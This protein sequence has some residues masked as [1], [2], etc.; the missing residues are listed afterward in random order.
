M[1]R[2]QPVIWTKGTILTPQHL[3]AQDRFIESTLQ[4]HLDALSFQPWG[5]REL[6]IDQAALASGLFSVSSAS[7]IFP[8]GLIFDV[9]DSDPP[10]APKPLPDNFGSG[11]DTL[12]LYL[13]IPSFQER[14]LNVSSAARGARTRYTAETAP[15]IDEN[16]GAS[17]RSIQIARKNLSILLESENL[18][19]SAS[20]RIARVRKSPAGLLQLDS[21]FIPPLLDISASDGLMAMVRGLSDRLSARSGGISETRRQKNPSL[22]DFTASDIANFWLLYTLNSHL[23]A[24]RHLAETRRAHPEALFAALLELAGALTAF[25]GKIR[26]RDLPAY[27]HAD[28]SSCFAE[29]EGKLKLL[30]ETVV[31]DNF[32]SFA[33]KRVR[34]SVYSTALTDEKYLS[35]TMYLAVSAGLDAAELGARVP[36]YIKVGSLDRVD[37]MVAKALSGVSLTHTASPPEAIRV[38][39]NYQYFRLDQS[40]KEWD[41]ICRAHNLAAF[42]PGDFGSPQLELIVIAPGR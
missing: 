21:R 38:K 8:D 22:A 31:P 28:L 23:P 24:L 39:R 9:P 37:E 10:P 41:A 11:R 32:I 26:P 18:E 30:L 2:L 34:S 29:L 17:E 40:G 1:T 27:D 19:G 7:G 6:R 36:Q 15:A 25:S 14:G 4:F 3:Q 33:L 16:T 42:V 5:F 12:D 13:A 20:M 35:Q